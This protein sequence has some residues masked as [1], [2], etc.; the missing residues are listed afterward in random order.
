LAEDYTGGSL[1]TKN[2]GVFMTVPDSIYSTK[3]GVATAIGYEDLGVT[4]NPKHARLVQRLKQGIEVEKEDGSKGT[5]K[6]NNIDELEDYN[7]LWKQQNKGESLILKI[8]GELI[9][10][11]DF[12]DYFKYNINPNFI[13]SKIENKLTQ[14]RLGERKI[15]TQLFITLAMV[16]LIMAIGFMVINN[17]FKTSGY[18]DK[19]EA[20]VKSLSQYKP[21]TQPITTTTLPT[22]NVGGQIPI[23]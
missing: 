1:D 3:N 20:C 16:F 18:Q 17:Y 14:E 12:I 7:E 8:G 23:G 2:N 6:I 19:W 22:G 5:V 11:Q 10:V 13:Q 21:Q 4:I 15:N 9:K